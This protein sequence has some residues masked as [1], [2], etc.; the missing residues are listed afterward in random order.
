M[1]GSYGTR[2]RGEGPEARGC[3]SCPLRRPQVAELAEMLSVELG[4]VLAA[5]SVACWL[6]FAL[7]L[8]RQDGDRIVDPGKGLYKADSDL[9]GGMQHPGRP[10]D[11]SGLA[12]TAAGEPAEASVHDDH[13]PGAIRST[14]SPVRALLPP[15]IPPATPL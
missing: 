12:L 13:F 10:K 4:N 14:V 7:R 11:A 15:R 9:A 3:L 5:V 6:R 1:C 2:G 8:P